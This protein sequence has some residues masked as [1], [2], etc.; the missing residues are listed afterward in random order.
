MALING[1][2]YEKVI[3]AVKPYGPKVGETWEVT[4]SKSTGAVH[5]VA[6]TT[7]PRRS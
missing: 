3:E 5:K 1:I 4:Y 2:D 7:T 6:R